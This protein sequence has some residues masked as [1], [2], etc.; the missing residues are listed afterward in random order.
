[1]EP[2]LPEGHEIFT[3]CHA[4]A[5]APWYR[6]EVTDLNVFFNQFQIIKTD[7]LQVFSH[8]LATVASQTFFGHITSSLQIFLALFINIKSTTSRKM[9]SKYTTS[10]WLSA[11]TSTRCVHLCFVLVSYL[12]YR[13]CV[14]CAPNQ[15]PSSCAVLALRPLILAVITLEQRTHR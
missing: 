13:V 14:V 3:K 1:M 10:N 8:I 7:W 11:R 2:E 9:I 4:E 5:S 6:C 12:A 15:R